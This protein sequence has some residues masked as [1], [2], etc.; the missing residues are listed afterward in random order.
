MKNMVL[1]FYH[2]RPTQKG[3]YFYHQVNDPDNKILVEVVQSKLGLAD[4]RTMVPIAKFAPGRWS[5]RLIGCNIIREAFEEGVR[6]GMSGD[7]ATKEKVEAL[8]KNS[9]HRHFLP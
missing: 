4:K 8:W 9:E 6:L 7:T 2:H 5:E 3:V 1:S